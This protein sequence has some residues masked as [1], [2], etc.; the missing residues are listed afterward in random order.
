MRQAT[1]CFLLRENEILLAMKKRGFGIGKWN[2]YGGKVQEGEEI[3][4][5]ALRELT[6]ESGVTAVQEAL[7]KVARLTF[8]FKD[9]PVWNQEVHV[10]FI[11]D[12]QGQ[13]SETEEMSPQWFAVNSLPYETMWQ[14][15]KEWLPLALAGKTVQGE[16]LFNSDGSVM[17]TW[18][19]QEAEF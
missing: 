5:A 13:E 4:Q 3:I 9:N 15:D 19:V 11:Q 16:F 7:V 14:D 6:E 17:E 18:Q 1:L 2:G 8:L 12:W 10:F